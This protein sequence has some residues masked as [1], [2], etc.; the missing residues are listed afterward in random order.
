MSTATD[1]PAQNE[2][3]VRKHR[4]RRK[5]R[6]GKKAR[7]RLLEEALR[8]VESHSAEDLARRQI[9]EHLEKTLAKWSA[10]L[11]KPDNLDSSK[12]GRKNNTSSPWQRPP[13]VLVTFGSY[14]LGV[15]RKDSDLDLLAI[16]PP[17]CSRHDFFT[18]LVQL[19]RDDNSI[20]QVHPIAT[21][22]TP[23]IKFV[24]FETHIDMLFARIHK[25]DKLL[26]YQLKRVSPLVSAGLTQ[27]TPR[28]EYLID[29]SDLVGQ[30][31]PG[32]R[33]LNGARVS[34]ILLERVP[35]LAN[36]RVV[37]RIVK[38]W[39][40]RQGIYSNVLGFLGGVNWAIL[41]AW[42]CL[43]Y[44]QASSSELLEAF[45][46]TY[47]TWE[48]PAPVLIAPLQD[49]P[50]PN[51]LPLPAWNPQTNP[52]DG[53]HIMPIITPAYPSMNSAYNVGIPQLRR[54]QDELIRA[55]NYFRNFHPNQNNLLA[56][57]DFFRRH[58]H[59]LQV[60]IRAN[61]RQDFVEW[62]RLVESRLRLLIV[63]LETTHVHSWPLARFFARFY[64]NQGN[65]IDQG[66]SEPLTKHE[67]FCFIGLRFAHGIDEL[68]LQ[69]LTSDFLHK[70]NS[71]ESRQPGMDLFLH[72]VT[73]DML[74]DECL[75]NDQQSIACDSP[76]MEW[77]I[78]PTKKCRMTATA[79]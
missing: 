77:L 47:A 43:R 78:S 36:Y 3:P 54:I 57:T 26:Q 73:R 39:A 40:N 19:L 72:H 10:S 79:G 25:P 71:W 23:V 60:T 15:H 41:V 76:K 56:E 34:Q 59:F 45:F 6:S 9:I 75:S 68:N 61:E 52:R 69:H 22:Y 51:V 33:S 17:N 5:N 74:P 31:E 49:T 38:E 67:A 20:A 13:P 8:K 18:S 64:D 24:L 35:N 55:C 53:L 2:S 62:F 37:L 58:A 50:P 32:L 29:D 48:W 12:D 65:R 66:P 42:V 63:A 27:S 21:A 46:R 16:C 14:R 11:S 4:Q 7:E 70:V 28:Q 44:P 1:A 30:D